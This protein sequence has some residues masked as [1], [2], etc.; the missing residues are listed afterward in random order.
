MTI[1][2]EN[3]LNPNELKLKREIVT[4]IFKNHES[5]KAAIRTEEGMITSDGERE[6]L[7][8][9]GNVELSEGKI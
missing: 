7:K 1:K 4:I 9:E 2:D 8:G 6:K 5:Y 3:E